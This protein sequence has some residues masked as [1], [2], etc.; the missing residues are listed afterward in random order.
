MRRRSGL[1]LLVRV[2]NQLQTR[3]ISVEIIEECSSTIRGA[4]VND[5]ASAVFSRLTLKRVKIEART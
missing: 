5:D 1:V 3:I 2:I 4:I